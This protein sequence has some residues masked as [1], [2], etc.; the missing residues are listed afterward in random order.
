MNGLTGV[1]SYIYSKTEERGEYQAYRCH[2]GGP[3]DPSEPPGAGEGGVAPWF[4]WEIVSGL[5]ERCHG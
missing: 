5:C 2:Q 4:P 1:I 3:Q